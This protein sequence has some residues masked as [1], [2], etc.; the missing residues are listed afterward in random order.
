MSLQF[1]S[2]DILYLL[3][4][5]KKKMP[6]LF[7]SVNEILLPR[8]KRDYGLEYVYNIFSRPL[9]KTCATREGIVYFQFLNDRI[10]QTTKFVL[11][12]N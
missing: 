6:Q 2:N 3:Q 5:S 12:L 1:K 4:K 11:F 10:D 8:K 9:K 7:F